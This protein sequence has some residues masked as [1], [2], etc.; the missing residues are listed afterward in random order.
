VLSP[1]RIIDLGLAK[2]SDE[3]GDQTAISTPGTFAGT[4]EFASPEQFAGLGVDI[5]SDLYSLGVTLWKM[6]TCELPFRGSPAEVMHQHL[7]APL[8]FDQLKGV[9]QPVVILLE[10]L[11]EKD[12]A[13]RFQDPTDLLKVISAMMR[14]V[15]ARRTLKHQ[16]LRMAL[17]QELNSRPRRLPAIRVPK[18]SIVVLPF[19][20]LSHAKGNTYFADGVQDEIL[21]NLAKVSQLKVISRTSVMTFRPGANRNLRSIAESLGVAN[22]GGHRA[23]RR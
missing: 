23:E 15:K 19:D 1:R 10:M 3:P 13:Q 16:N 4:P 20:T 17:I 18:R 14:A 21:S 9:P 8:P 2:T 5:R 6:V 7:N 22:I 12:P 11:L